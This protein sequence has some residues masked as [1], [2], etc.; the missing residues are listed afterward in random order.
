M[1][2]KICTRSFL[3]D[4]LLAALYVALFALAIWIW[5]LRK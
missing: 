3:L 2:G 1:K 5:G 4:L